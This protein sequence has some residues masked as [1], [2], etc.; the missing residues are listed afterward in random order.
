MLAGAQLGF[1]TST[2][3][4][5]SGIWVKSGLWLKRQFGRL[6]CGFSGQGRV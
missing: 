4:G 3:M 5:V 1:G 2:R 6:Q